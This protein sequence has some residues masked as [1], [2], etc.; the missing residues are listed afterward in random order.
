[1]NGF[2]LPE[3]SRSHERSRILIVVAVFA[4]VYI[5]SRLFLLMHFTPIGSDVD[6]YARFAF[7]HA[8]AQETGTPFYRLYRAEGLKDS[9][10]A[11]YSL[12]DLTTIPYPPLAIGFLGIPGRVILHGRSTDSVGFQNFLPRYLKAYR[13][14]C[15]PFDCAV[16]LV[17]LWLIITLFRGERMWLT[18]VRS[19]MTCGI[20]ALLPHLLYDRLDIVLLAFLFLSLVALVK[21]RWIIAFALFAIAVDFKP[22][23]LFLAPLWVLGS[24]PAAGLDGPR[25]IMVFVKQFAV[26]GLF[27]VIMTACVGM[28][29]LAVEG[30]QGLGFLGF[31]GARGIH[32]ES[33]WGTFSL[34]AAAIFNLP[35]R[36]IY[37]FG[38]FNVVTSW[39]P[40]CTV[41]AQLLLIALTSGLAIAAA[42]RG[43]S[44]LGT[45]EP[46]AAMISQQSLISLTAAMLLLTF[47]T[48]KMFS[49]QF[50]LLLVPIIP[51]ISSRGPIVIVLCTLLAGACCMSTYIYPYYYECEIILGPTPFG[52]FLLV[53]REVMLIAMLC[54]IVTAEFRPKQG[55]PAYSAA[56]FKEKQE[57]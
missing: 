28:A 37:D 3:P 24:I 53:T 13:W 43:L 40:F 7:I 14:T 39:T 2:P 49:P 21:K 25:R 36:I 22:L 20:A 42:L 54:C 15:F 4:A 47:C 10:Y 11:S 46:D 38:A 55:V 23:P 18:I 30:W 41:A 57:T 19:G 52:H 26:R 34:L 45:G 32:I 51:I 50:L 5:P 9:T 56:G 35:F 48:F 1:M 31:H 17:A 6:L 8:K 33:S 27:L 16:V 29:S 44:S 12:R